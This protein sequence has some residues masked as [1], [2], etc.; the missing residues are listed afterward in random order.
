MLWK[1]FNRDPHNNLTV[2]KHTLFVFLEGKLYIGI[3]KCMKHNLSRSTFILEELFSY[4]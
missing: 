1:I 3:N 2:V 4:S